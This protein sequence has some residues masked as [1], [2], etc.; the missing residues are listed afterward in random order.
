M[1]PNFDHPL[2]CTSQKYGRNIG[3]P[4]YVVNGC[5]VGGISLQKSWTVFG[6]TLV[7]QAFICTHQK[8]GII[9]RIEGYTS[10]SIPKIEY[11]I[12][13]LMVSRKN[14]KQILN[15][16]QSKWVCFV[17]TKN[18]N[19]ETI[20]LVKFGICFSWNNVALTDSQLISRIFWGVINDLYP[21]FQIPVI[22]NAIFSA[23]NR[24]CLSTT[25]VTIISYLLASSCSWYLLQKSY[26]MFWKTLCS[27]YQ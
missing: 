14:E 16:L 10:T 12:V 4:R 6:G 27:A 17:L 11:I 22:Y 9:H 8:H 2:S 3:I 20:W 13:H 24:R 21:K 5:V 26:A 15:F 7:N 25:P 18:E 23:K 19:K 1:I